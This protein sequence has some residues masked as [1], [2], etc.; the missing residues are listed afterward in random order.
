MKVGI[1]QAKTDAVGCPMKSLVEALP[2]EI[3]QRIHPQWRKNEADYWASREE[4]LRQYR[5][6]WIGFSEGAVV[7]AGESPVE[8]FHTAHDLAKHPFVTCVG[9]E[10]EP[11]RMRRVVFRYDTAYRG[12]ALPVV[13]VEFR[14]EPSV[15][16]LLLDHVIPDTGADATA[17]PWSDCEQ[18]GLDPADGAPS[19]LGGVGDT[20]APTLVFRALGCQASG[21]TPPCSGR[22]DP[23]RRRYA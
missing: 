20:V 9:R 17:L 12:E 5:G 16:G 15:P 3:A 11:C 8:V 2:P 14:T 19:L 6:L 13:T 23:D 10:H 18:L 7:A 4:L 21:L 22:P 1:A